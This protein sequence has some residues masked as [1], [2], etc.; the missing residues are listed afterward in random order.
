M[1][2]EITITD[3]KFLEV[4]TRIA[5]EIT[6]SFTEYFKVGL[7]LSVI[8]AEIFGDEDEETKEDKFNTLFEKDIDDMR[9]SIH[10]GGDVCKDDFVLMKETLPGTKVVYTCRYKTLNDAMN[11]L[12]DEIS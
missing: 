6:P 11:A 4:S 8:A 1:A 3:K 10:T 9:Y 12:I 5:N 2:K 7:V